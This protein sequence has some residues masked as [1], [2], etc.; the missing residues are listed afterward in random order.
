MINYSVIIPHGQS[1][2]TLSRAID[3]VPSREDI[4]VIVV[5][6]SKVS[7]N[8]EEVK[9]T[10]EY[11]LYYSNPCRHAGGAR[12]E[13]IIHSKGQYLL[14]LDADDFYVEGAFSVFDKYINLQYDIVYFNVISKYSDSLETCNRSEE[15]NALFETYHKRH[16]INIFRYKYYTPWCKLFLRQFIVSNNI[17]FDEVEVCNDLMF[18]MRTGVYANN[19]FADDTKLYCV[20]VRKGSLV[21]HKTK[22][23]SRTRFC[24]MVNQ[25]IFMKSVGLQQ[26]SLRLQ[27]MI[28]SALRNYGIKECG[29][30]IRYAKS[31]NVSVLHGG[32]RFV[33]SVISKG[34]KQIHFQNIKVRNRV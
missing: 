13:G 6:N 16:D 17:R 1:L 24:I 11:S 28:L 34:V 32:G 26:Y 25:C 5:D 20:T 7:I 31:K 9:A 18:S 23:R 22:E 19:V 21:Y 10:R 29:W 12:N 2:D 27:S 14:F 3:S 8:K 30:Y 4:E 15:T 33:F